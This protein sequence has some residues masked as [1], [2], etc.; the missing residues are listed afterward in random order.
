MLL[1]D[2]QGLRYAEIAEVLDAFVEQRTTRCAAYGLPVDEIPLLRR[3]LDRATAPAGP[4]G[5]AAGPVEFHGLRCGSRIV[6]T[7]GGVRRRGR[8]SGMLTSFTAH[9]DLKRTSPGELLLAE[10][11]RHDCEKGTA[12][13]DLGVGEARYKETYCPDVEPLFDSLVPLTP[14]GHV[15]ARAEALKL[16]AKRSIKQSRWAW[17]LVQRL[18]KLRAALSRGRADEPPGRED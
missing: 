5:E 1:S 8:F 12:T 13:F 6:A 18:R 2:V 9:A 4:G 14:R 11:M 7:L 15:H 17:P 16:Q 3:F 10:V